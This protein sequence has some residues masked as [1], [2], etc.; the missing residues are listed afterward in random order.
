MPGVFPGLAGSARM[1]GDPNQVVAIVLHGFDSHGDPAAPRWPARMQPLAHLSDRMIAD[2]VSFAR[3]S[4]GNQAP[5]ITAEQVAR[6]RAQ[7]SHRDRP[8]TPGD[9]AQ[10]TM[11]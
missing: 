4:W 3:S 11:P 6:I 7:L 9:L 1:T 10:A 2:A 5:A 8:W